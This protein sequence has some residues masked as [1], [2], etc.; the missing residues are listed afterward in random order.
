MKDGMLTIEDQ[1]DEENKLQEVRTKITQKY[2]FGW[3]GG[4]GRSKKNN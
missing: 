2:W 3:A 4:Y 1:K